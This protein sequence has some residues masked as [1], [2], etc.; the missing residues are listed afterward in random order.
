MRQHESPGNGH[1]KA[2]V[3]S[4][5]HFAVGLHKV[6]TSVGRRLREEDGLTDWGCGVSLKELLVE[7]LLDVGDTSLLGGVGAEGSTKWLEEESKHVHL[8]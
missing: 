7:A 3:F 8:L 2:T 5:I 1:A 4:P 6:S